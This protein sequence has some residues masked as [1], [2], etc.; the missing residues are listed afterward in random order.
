M[1]R[2]EIIIVSLLQ[3]DWAKAAAEFGCSRVWRGPER[4]RAHLCSDAG[5]VWAAWPCSTSCR[6]L[7]LLQVDFSAVCLSRIGIYFSPLLPVIQILKCFILFYVKK[8]NP[9]A[10][11]FQMPDVIVLPCLYTCFKKLIGAL[12]YNWQ[13]F[14]ESQAGRLVS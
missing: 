2:S 9:R 1:L 8:V 7:T 5:L 3:P 6:A 13:L 14:R 11:L 10:S 12:L 4:L